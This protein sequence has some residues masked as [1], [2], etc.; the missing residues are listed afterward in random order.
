MRFTT[1]LVLLLCLFCIGCQQDEAQTPRDLLK[2]AAE[3]H[4][5]SVNGD[6]VQVSIGPFPIEKINEWKDFSTKTMQIRT[7]LG[8][9]KIAVVFDDSGE[10][11]IGVSIIWGG[12]R[13]NANFPFRLNAE[14]T[15]EFVSKAIVEMS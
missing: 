13:S 1:L 7:N 8:I 15:V 14:E 11:I 9:R 5:L 10:E 6:G 3:Q 4:N 2:A 12:S